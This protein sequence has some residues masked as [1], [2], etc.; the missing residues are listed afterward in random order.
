MLVNLGKL[1]YNVVVGNFCHGQV[2]KGLGDV[3]SRVG[4]MQIILGSIHLILLLAITVCSG[5]ELLEMDPV[6]V[7]LG[8]VSPLLAG[9]IVK[10]SGADGM[11]CCLQ[12]LLCRE[13]DVAIGGILNIVVD[14]LEIHADRLHGV[15][16][17]IHLLFAFLEVRGGNF[18]IPTEQMI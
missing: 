15:D 2:A 18:P 13:I 14:A 8:F 7:N 5:E 12:D 9:F 6:F 1:G 3:D 17:F 11:I 16:G 10:T 4:A